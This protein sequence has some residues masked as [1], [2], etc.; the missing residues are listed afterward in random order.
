MFL[1]PMCLSP[2]VPNDGDF[3]DILPAHA[4]DSASRR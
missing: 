2:A 3:R 1:V 4:P